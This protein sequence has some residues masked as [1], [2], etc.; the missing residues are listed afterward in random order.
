MRL[1][2]RG[3]VELTARVLIVE[4]GSACARGGGG[5]GGGGVR[6]RQARGSWDS[7]EKAAAEMESG[8]RLLSTAMLLRVFHEA[9]GFLYLGPR[10]R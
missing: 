10:G 7:D 8:R 6:S 1:K 9:R 5:G 3:V 4:S 2:T